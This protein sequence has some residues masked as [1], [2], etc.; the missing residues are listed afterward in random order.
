MINQE[1]QKQNVN[2]VTTIQINP[3]NCL[4]IGCTS[5][6]NEEDLRLRKEKETNN[7]KNFFI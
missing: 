5:S 4:V 6:V 7:K 3:V 1:K 2:E